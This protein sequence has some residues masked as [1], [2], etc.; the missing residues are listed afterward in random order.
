MPDRGPTLILGVTGSIAAYK[1]LDLI[2]RLVGEGVSVHVVATSKARPFF[3][4]MA[5]EVL[6]GHRVETN[7]FSRKPYTQ[8]EKLHVPHLSLLSRADAVLVA[9]ASA[10]F[11]ARLALGL[12]D[13]LLSTML[14]SA[15]VPVVIAPAMEE[16]MYLHPASAGHRHTL[17]ERGVL[18]IPP[19]SGSLASG[20][21][22]LGRMASVDQ[23]LSVI[24][25]ILR[26]RRPPTGVLSG[27]RVL[28]SSGPT[29]E[30]ID[31]VRFLGN[32]SSGLMGEALARAAMARGAQ[33]TV[34]S[35]PTALPPLPGTTHYGVTTTR[36][37]EDRLRELFPAHQLLIMA[38][39]VSDYRP[40]DPLPVKRKKDGKD[41][42]LQL[43][44]NRDILLGLAE[45][46]QPGQFLIGFAAESVL[47]PAALIKKCRSKKVDLLV[48]NDIS[49]SETGFASTQNEVTLVSPEGSINAFSRADKR[50]VA[51]QI[52][53]AV[54]KEGWPP[55]P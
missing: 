46:R 26:A 54:C 27:V 42:T 35:G 20:M 50:V 33:V 31:S 13:D 4:A 49:N 23:I 16:A 55:A 37:M 9:P 30:P 7:L 3:P 39:A 1:A 52:L 44:E 51:E 28:I 5:A 48:A 2:R 36:E 45:M 43:A 14:L 12:A 21:T 24:L 10:D 34:V 22:G 19:E 41:W 17:N 11:I 8:E 25:P 47:D 40:R 15:K 38:A 29:F 32:R 18:E 53:D 6:S